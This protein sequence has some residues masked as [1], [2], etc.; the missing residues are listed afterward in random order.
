MKLIKINTEAKSPLSS[1]EGVGSQPRLCGDEAKN[2][3]LLLSKTSELPKIAEL[4]HKIWNI[5]YP[6]IVGQTQVDYMLNK[7]YSLPALEQQVAG[8][9]Q[10]YFTENE[11]QNIG[12]VA[13]TLKETY[14]LFINKFYID[15]SQQGK[16]LGKQVFIAIQQLYPHITKFTLTVNRQNYT[17]INF[18]FKIGFTIKEVADFD[19]GDSYVMNDFVME[20]PK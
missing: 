7:F 19:I 12:F 11:G 15:N 5:H 20:W 17:A 18:Y 1:G 14:H 4:A 3:K 9:Q 10:F 13:L 16:G 2:M 8:G 6:P